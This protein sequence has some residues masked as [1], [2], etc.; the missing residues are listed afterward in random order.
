M[1]Y[2]TAGMGISSA[3]DRA[4]AASGSYDEIGTFTK[5]QQIGNTSTKKFAK[6]IT[7]ETQSVKAAGEV[8]R[9]P[10]TTNYLASISYRL[11]TVN[12]WD[13]DLNLAKEI[14]DVP[15]LFGED[16]T[17]TEDSKT[18]NATD[19]NGD[20]I[21]EEEGRLG[22]ARDDYGIGTEGEFSSSAAAGSQSSSERKRAREEAENKSTKGLLGMKTSYVPDASSV[23]LYMPQALNINDT[24]NYNINANLGVRGAAALSAI[25]NAG[26][27]YEGAKAALAESFSGL[28]DLFN[29][30]LAGQ[31]A[32]LAASRASRALPEDLQT[33]AQ[34]GLQV[35]VNPNTRALFEG[36]NIRQFTFQY[37]FIATSSSEAEQVKN[38]VKFFRTELYPSTFGRKEASVP[39]GYKFPNLFEIKFR[40]GESS[41]DMPQ[42]I[43]CYLRDVQTTYNPGSMSWHADG[44][45]TQISMTLMFNEWRALTREDVEEGY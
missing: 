14:F 3:A 31:A 37:D 34:L 12:P 28:T 5:P 11:K 4:R 24:V 13:V 29:A 43:L 6:P 9:Y 16:G 7:G 35:K 44:N 32:R 27:L 8:L 1:G 39:I 36:V 25:N 21:P 22:T 20:S 15:L 18:K 19:A 40:W 17:K 41:M 10:I 26:G 33:A 23:I 30:N 2:D 38:I 42:P 45:P